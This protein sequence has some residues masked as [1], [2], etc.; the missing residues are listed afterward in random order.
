MNG[1]RAK[2]PSMVMARQLH[3]VSFHC[4]VLVGAARITAD[5][6][7]FHAEGILEQPGNVIAGA[8][9]AGGRTARRVVSLAQLVERFGGRVGTHE[10][11]VA[12]AVGRTDP[13]I[14]GPVELRFFA[15]GQ[16]RHNQRAAEGAQRQSIG[17]GHV[18]DMIGR[19]HRTGARHVL[20]HEGGIAG[21]ILAHEARVGARILIMIVARL[22]ADDDADGFAL[23]ERR[24]L[25]RRRF[26]VQRVQK[27]KGQNKKSEND[28]IERLNP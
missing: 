4:Q 10:E 9:D 22:V 25:R 19:D 11:Q 1:S 3:F 23:I 18:V 6:F 28:P 26:K 24:R 21:N 27:F 12:G 14:L 15:S 16:L 5:D 20:N 13:T 7:E 2:K 8:A 17:L